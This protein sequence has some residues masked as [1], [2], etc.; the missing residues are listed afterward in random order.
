METASGEMCATAAVLMVFVLSVWG[1]QSLLHTSLSSQTA[2]P[3]H[4]YHA[5]PQLEMIEHMWGGGGFLSKLS[6]CA[7]VAVGGPQIHGPR[8]ALEICWR[9]SVI[10][11]SV[12]GRDSAF[13]FFR[14]SFEESFRRE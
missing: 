8:S 11:F 14:P 6:L 9:H 10:I 5:E 7:E 2:N 1:G 13:F 12:V 4:I 3:L